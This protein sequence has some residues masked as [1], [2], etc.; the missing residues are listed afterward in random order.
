MKRLFA[1][2]LALFAASAGAQTVNLAPSMEGVFNGTYIIPVDKYTGGWQAAQWPN[3]N[4]VADFDPGVG[5]SLQSATAMSGGA[6][7]TAPKA[8]PLRPQWNAYKS[9]PSG[10]YRAEWTITK[11]CGASAVEAPLQAVRMNVGPLW[12]W[13][14]HTDLPNGIPYP[15]SKTFS[16]TRV[17][18]NEVSYFTFQLDAN[19]PKA[20]D[21]KQQFGC[22]YSLTNLSLTAL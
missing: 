11:N 1:I 17:H 4:R 20:T 16:Y 12:T 18:S 3:P 14:K 8:Y 6:K 9:L 15:V 5:L 21:G 22:K 19:P 13:T 2:I 7:S 10:N